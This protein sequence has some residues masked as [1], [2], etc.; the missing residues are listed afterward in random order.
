MENNEY[1][2]FTLDK[3]NRFKIWNIQKLFFFSFVCFSSGNFFWFSPNMYNINLL[4]IKY[5]LDFRSDEISF[6]SSKHFSN[7]VQKKES[8][9][10]SCLTCLYLTASVREYIFTPILTKGLHPYSNI[11]VSTLR[12]TPY[13]LHLNADIRKIAIPFAQNRFDSLASQESWRLTVGNFKLEI[14]M[15]SLCPQNVATISSSTVRKVD[16]SLRMYRYYHI[17]I[18]SSVIY[19]A[20]T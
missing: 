17:W 1:E 6:P 14:P 9:T 15:K 11:R 4:H 8:N 13:Y 5:T 7:L 19:S 12:P 10:S 18:I 2:C 3:S 20:C 16:N